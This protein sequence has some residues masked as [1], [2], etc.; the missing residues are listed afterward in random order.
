MDLRVA[1]DL[2][3]ETK[4]QIEGWIKTYEN[5]LKDFEVSLFKKKN[6]GRRVAV[7]NLQNLEKL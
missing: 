4:H 2:R 3:Q 1:S 6:G 5:G 7:I